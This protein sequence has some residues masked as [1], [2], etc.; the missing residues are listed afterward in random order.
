MTSWNAG[1]ERIYG[2]AADEVLG[3]PGIFMVPPDRRAESADT[4]ERIRSGEGVRHFETVRLRKDGTQFDVSLT[5]SPS[6]RSGSFPLS[7]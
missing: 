1:A 6:V 7:P 4:V 5:V 3:R 2:Y